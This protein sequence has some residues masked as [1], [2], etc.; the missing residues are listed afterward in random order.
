MRKAPIL[1]AATADRIEAP[2]PSQRAG[3]IILPVLWGEIK[4]E[5]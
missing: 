5:K 4:E 1:N 2:K 3:K